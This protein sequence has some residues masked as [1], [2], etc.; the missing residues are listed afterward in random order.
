[1]RSVVSSLSELVV[2]AIMLF[3]SVAALV[4]QDGAEADP[5]REAT[6][7]W[8]S[9][10]NGRT[11]FEISDPVLVPSRLALAA[12][13]SGCRYKEA[14][15]EVPLRFIR[16]SGA[17]LPWCSVLGLLDHISCSIFRT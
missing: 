11:D 6:R 1:M 2:A 7:E 12:T 16:A 5:R 15:N 8:Q 3:A 14:I 9:L 4:G 10:A 17:V 13:Q